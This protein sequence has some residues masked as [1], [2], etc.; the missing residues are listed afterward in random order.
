MTAPA[1]LTSA[2][3]VAVGSE[4]LETTKL[5]TNSLFITELLNGIGID[6]ASKHIAGDDR[7]V[8]R[9]VLQ[10]ALAGA[11]L[12]AVCGG[13]GIVADDAMAGVYGQLLRRGLVFVAPAGWL[14]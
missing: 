7:A 13:L 8:L 3:I 14:T 1:V 6:V 9:R 10:S 11:D 2:A 4:L 12:V 5:D